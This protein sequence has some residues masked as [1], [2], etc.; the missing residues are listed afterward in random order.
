MIQNAATP[1]S[2]TSGENPL[3]PH[4]ERFGF[5]VLD[6]GLATALERS[7]HDLRD[8]LWSARLLLDDP[9]AIGAVHSAYLRAGADCITT[10]AYQATVS[11]LEGRGVSR[12]EAVAALRRSTELALA[13]VRGARPKE[14]AQ[15]SVG[16]DGAPLAPLV[17]ASVGPYGAWLADGS[18]YD[19]RY[20]R[21]V[22]ELADFHRERFELL[23]GS[24]AD[25]LACETIPSAK[26]TEALLDV[27]EGTPDCW[28]WF[29]FTCADD[30]VIRDGTPIEEV[31]D[32]CAARERVAA[33]GL[34]CTEPRWAGMIVERIRERTDLPVVVY[35]NSGELYDGRTK[36]WSAGSGAT[37]WMEGLRAAWAAGARVV[38]GCCR[39]GPDEIRE[40]R[41]RV[42]SG[43]FPA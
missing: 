21:S 30:R 39:T 18:E 25:L 34:N 24:G 9:S 11:G 10:S 22:A 16:G 26:E 13:A 43:D 29:S 37:S 12:D 20:G 1:D 42:A 8:E 5:V 6:G 4:L 23:A 28:A 36:S 14:E 41:S 17:A 19:G 7:G 33:V 2:V 38:G 32:A 27:H 3:S 31:V 35:P 15:A 40:L